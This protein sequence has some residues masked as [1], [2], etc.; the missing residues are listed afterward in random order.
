MRLTG[1]WQN[2]SQKGI[3]H[4]SGK[5]GRNTKL[6]VFMN[7]RKTNEKAPDYNLCIASQDREQG[8][9]LNVTGLWKDS[10]R[11]D[12]IAAGL[13]GLCEFSLIKNTKKSG[14]TDPDFFLCVEQAKAREAAPPQD[15][16]QTDIPF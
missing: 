6:L 1:L 4:L 3:T 9:M 7:E 13:C 15:D 8:G 5:F 11:K 16:P 2:K 14:E 10:Q 12:I